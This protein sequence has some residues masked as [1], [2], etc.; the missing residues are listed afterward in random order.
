MI[1]RTGKGNLPFVILLVILGCAVACGGGAGNDDKASGSGTTKIQEIGSN[2]SDAQI[3]AQALE[4]TRGDPVPT[5]EPS[6]TPLA[7]ALSQKP[8]S[9]PPNTPSAVPVVTLGGAS[10]R[11]EL[12]VTPD[13]RAQG[14]S[15]RANLAIGTGMLFVYKNEVSP[16][17]WMKEMRFPL[18]IVWIDARCRVAD[19][20]HDVPPPAPDQALGDLPTYAPSVPVQYVLEI[21]AGEAMAAG[22]RRGDPVEFQGISAC[23]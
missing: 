1:S 6:S 5:Q 12:A 15:G 21:N 2:P 13:Q 8:P 3:P 17:F 22:L 20:T 23:P 16:P 7:T 4:S 19:I 9:T 11:M 10:F 14:L 18:D